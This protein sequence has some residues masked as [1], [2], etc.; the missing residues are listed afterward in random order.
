MVKASGA[1]RPL[2]GKLGRGTKLAIQFGLAGLTWSILILIA[3][4]LGLL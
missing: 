1:P 3:V 4:L 2:L